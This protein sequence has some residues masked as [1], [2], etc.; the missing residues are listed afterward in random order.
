MAALEIVDSRVA[1][2]DITYADTVADNASC[3]LYTVS[4]LVVPL[5]EVEPVDIAMV[6]TEGVR[7]SRSEFRRVSVLSSGLECG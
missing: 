3:G 5:T 7:C 4:D 6:S 1:D 2:W